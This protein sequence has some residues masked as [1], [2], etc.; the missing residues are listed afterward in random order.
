MQKYCILVL[1]QLSNFVYLLCE[2]LSWMKH[3][4]LIG[5]LLFS[6]VFPGFS[7][8]VKYKDLLVLLIAENYTDADKYLRA[9]LKEEP[10][11]PHANYYM[12]RMLQSYLPNQDLLN[13]SARVIEMSDSSIMYFGMAINLTTEKYIKK[14][15]RANSNNYQ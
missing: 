7:Q 11:H 3:I 12:G 10:E 6:T 9:Y 2:I 5:F 8:K 15:D 14:R 1:C 13:N 4:L